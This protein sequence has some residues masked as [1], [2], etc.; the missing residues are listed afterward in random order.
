MVEE[1]TGPFVERFDRL[2]VFM[3]QFKIKDLEVLR[4]SVITY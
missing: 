2:H 3:A 4:D 1:Q